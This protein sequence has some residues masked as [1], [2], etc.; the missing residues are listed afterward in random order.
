MPI[1]PP[2]SESIVTILVWIL[3]ISFTAIGVMG[4]VVAWLFKFFSK[5]EEKIIEPMTDSVDNMAESL[6][7]V[8]RTVDT[9]GDTVSTI[10]ETVNEHLKKANGLERDRQLLAN[11]KRIDE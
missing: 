9:F 10:G 8:V 7:D 3:G 2:D 4:V 11:S 1:T 6:G 5:R